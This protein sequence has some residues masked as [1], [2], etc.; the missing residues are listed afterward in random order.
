MEVWN[1]SSQARYKAGKVSFV[2][3]VVLCCVGTVL[4]FVILLVIDVFDFSKFKNVAIIISF[5]CYCYNCHH[6]HHHQKYNHPPSTSPLHEGVWCRWIAPSSD[7]RFLQR[8]ECPLTRQQ[9]RGCMTLSCARLA[10]GR[11]WVPGQATSRGLSN[12]VYI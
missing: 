7:W 9:R 6:N 2:C 1:G 5:Y 12:F 8:A 3:C 4:W 11:E 10:L